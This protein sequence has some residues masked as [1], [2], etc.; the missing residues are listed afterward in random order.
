MVAPTLV[1]PTFPAP[2]E[3]RTPRVSLRQWKDSDMADWITMNA[4]PEVRQYFPTVLTAEMAFAEAGRIRAAFSQRGWGLWAV[5]VP[6]VFVFAGF[7]GLMV[8]AY[9][10]PW[11]PAVE[12][13]WRLRRDAW[14]KGYAS[15]GAEAALQFAFQHL[16]L[17][18][19]V[20]ISVPT[21][22]PSHKV[23]ERLGMVRDTSA[24]F[25]HPKVPADWPY[26]RHILHRHTK[27]TWAMHT[28]KD[29]R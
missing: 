9:E 20:A 26:K 18:E 27:A 1:L 16:A 25:D 13:G 11:M 14:G 29:S 6:G 12:I 23:M 4:D 3:L 5:E 19:V 10:A 15:E 22:T 8:P 21:N 17:P 7:V 24:D 2:V 28:A